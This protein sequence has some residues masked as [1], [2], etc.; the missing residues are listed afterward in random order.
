MEWL[1]KATG[2]LL[3]MV[4]RLCVRSAVWLSDGDG[5]N[6]EEAGWVMLFMKHAENQCVPDCGK[7]KKYKKRS[8]TIL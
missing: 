8:H 5:G 2:L 1:R 7:F 6:G 4:A 3:W